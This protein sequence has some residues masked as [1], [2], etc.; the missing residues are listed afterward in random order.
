MNGTIRAVEVEAMNPIDQ[1]LQQL[2]SAVK[3]YEAGDGQQAEKTVYAAYMMIFEGLEGELIERDPDLV[4]QLEIDFNAGLPL[5]FKQGAPLAEVRDQYDSMEKNLKVAKQLLA[6]T[7][8][9][10]SSV[11]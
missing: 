3:H 7:E 5:L 10:R 1:I 8:A 11:F 2:Q 9:E 4:F 6:E